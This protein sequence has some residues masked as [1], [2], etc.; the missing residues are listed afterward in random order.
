VAPP[1]T[2]TPSVPPPPP[3]G[4]ARWT[5]AA[6]LLF[7]AAA[8]G[9]W[10][11][12]ESERRVAVAPDAGRPAAP[13][14]KPPKPAPPP[15]PAPAA[16]V[17]PP[18][19][20]PRPP[21]DAPAPPPPD[22]RPPPPPDAPPP[23]APDDDTDA[24]V[25]PEEMEEPVAEVAPEQPVR[26]EEI[27]SVKPPPAPPPPVEVKTVADAEALITAGKSSEAI[28]ALERLREKNLKSAYIPYLLGNLYFERKWWTDG[29][30]AY[31]AAIR[32]NRAYRDR[33]VLVRN[34]I[35]ALSSAKTV[36]RARTL[37]LKD[38]GMAGVPYLRL[39][40]RGDPNGT[41]RVRANAILGEL[42]RR[43]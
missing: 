1:P 19:D 21:P 8:V 34:A 10:R 39:A 6:L 41:V 20:A 43:R 14:A 4:R 36:S 11:F 17:A 13:P 24:T 27:D 29:L 2:P 9:A 42:A 30:E 40:A 22:A 33:A 18:P 7:G 28:A 15:R 31:H 3:A 12:I 38:V 32:A 25:P 16:V 35:R 5:V 23:D 37:L 26:D